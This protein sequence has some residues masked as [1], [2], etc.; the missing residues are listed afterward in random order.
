[1][2]PEQP[3]TTQPRRSKSIAQRLLERISDLPPRQRE[4][5]MMCW[6]PG[7]SVAE[8]SR[9]L[10]IAPGTVKATLYQARRRIRRA[11]DPQDWCFMSEDSDE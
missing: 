5:A 6:L 9:Q 7:F 10:S 4:I 2:A 3:V 11:T 8:A 1:V